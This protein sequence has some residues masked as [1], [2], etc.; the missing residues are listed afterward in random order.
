MRT[1]ALLAL[2]ALVT[3]YLMHDA[4]AGTLADLL[5]SWAPRNWFVAIPA[6][7]IFAVSLPRGWFE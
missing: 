2:W 7:C 1:V 3:A 4:Q 5:A 6:H